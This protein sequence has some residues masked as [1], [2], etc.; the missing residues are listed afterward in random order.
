MEAITQRANA[1]GNSGTGVAS[2]DTRSKES[3]KSPPAKIGDSNYLAQLNPQQLPG[4]KIR[5][6]TSKRN[7]V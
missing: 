4:R 6:Q 1:K 5:H 2:R 7:Y 3:V